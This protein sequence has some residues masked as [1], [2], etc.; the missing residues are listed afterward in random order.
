MKY[1]IIIFNEKIFLKD[2]SKIWKKERERIF[3]K[4]EKLKTD[5]I[6]N[7]QVKRLKNYKI[8]DF[9]LRIW[10]YRLLF[11]IDLEKSEIY[12]FRIL[13]RSKLY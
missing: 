11:N 3:L 13:H 6:K 12:L 10:E 2:L 5:E 8:A 7:A 9:R 1:K 4:I